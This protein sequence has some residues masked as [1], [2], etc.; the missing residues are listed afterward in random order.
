MSATLDSTNVFKARAIAIGVDPAIFTEFVTAGLTTMSKLSFLCGIQPG[1]ADDK[2]FLLA[3]RDL[4]ARMQNES[5]LQ[6][7]STITSGCWQCQLYQKV[8]TS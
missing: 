6:A 4:K 8:V 1:S 2:P 3:I 5:D 7:A